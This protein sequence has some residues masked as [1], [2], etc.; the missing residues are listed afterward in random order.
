MTRT[1]WRIFF[2]L[3]IFWTL[4]GCQTRQAELGM[5]TADVLRGP[6]EAPALAGEGR[7]ALYG[8]EVVAAEAQAAKLAAA[9]TA[10]SSRAEVLRG[11]YEAPTLGGEGR[12]A[13]YGW[14]VVAAEA[15]GGRGEI[16]TA[17]V[18][19]APYDAPGLWTAVPADELAGY[20]HPDV[21]VTTEWLATHLGEPGLRVI[22]VRRP[23]GVANF[24]VAHIPTAQYLDLIVDLM[25]HD[26]NQMA[27]DLIKAESFAALMGRLGIAN[28]STVVV[29]DAEG[30]TA[31]ATL[32]W[33]LR[34]YGHADV[35]LLNGGL[36]KWLLEGRETTYAA[37]TYAPSVYTVQVHSDLLATAADVAAAQED[38][39]AFLVDARPLETYTGASYLSAA[40]RAGHVPG[41]HTL[42]ARW[43]IDPQRK[44]ILPGEQLAVTL[45]MMGISPEQRG[46]AYCGNGQLA[47]FDA[48]LLSLMGYDQVAVYDSGWLEWGT[49]P[50]MPVE[51]GCPE[52][53]P[54]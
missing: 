13:L 47:A 1:V 36:V 30:G 48:L 6:Y 11:P 2:I 31:A 3:C 15:Q 29:Y 37:T 23:T 8:W 18:L 49:L 33:A 19:R 28:D 17:D 7:F 14:E 9:Q 20:V 46:I 4:A 26:P 42:P 54:M 32:W 51:T 27:L 39:T 40:P 44:T 45:A 25:D 41:S 50:E 24:A 16:A 53:E 10:V 22:D 34:Y 5:P 35:H 52:C 38:P 21:L 43:Q 12:F